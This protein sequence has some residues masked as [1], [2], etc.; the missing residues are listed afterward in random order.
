[1]DNAEDA[2]QNTWALSNK[3]KNV[4]FDPSKKERSAQ[5]VFEISDED[6]EGKHN[7]FL[8]ADIITLAPPLSCILIYW[9]Q[10]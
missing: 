1:M 9:Q 5:A 2:V 3:G 8:L 6:K 4:P 7:G 10:T